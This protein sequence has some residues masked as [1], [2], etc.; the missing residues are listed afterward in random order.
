MGPTPCHAASKLGLDKLQGD[1][2]VTRIRP[3]QRRQKVGALQWRIEG[4]DALDIAFCEHYELG[5]FLVWC[6]M[7]G[8]QG[9]DGST[10]YGRNSADW[11]RVRRQ[12]A[13]E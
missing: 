4:E 9:W 13:A 8:G 6:W 11:W 1:K 5:S 7:D 3:D 12:G 2:T 10:I